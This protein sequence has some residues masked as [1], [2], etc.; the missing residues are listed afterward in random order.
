MRFATLL[1]LG[2]SVLAAQDLA[3]PV[4][5]RVLTAGSQPV[6]GARVVVTGDRGREVGVT[7]SQGDGRWSIPDLPPGDLHIRAEK[8]G[9]AEAFRQVRVPASG[10][11]TGIALHIDRY[12]VLGGRIFDHRGRPVV[13][14]EPVLFEAMPAG[15]EVRYAPARLQGTTV[16]ATDDRGVFRIWGILPGRYLVAVAPPSAPSV[17]GTVL[18]ESS[19]AFY[20][21]VISA[22]EATP[23]ELGWAVV[24]E[25]LDFRLPP[26]GKTRVDIRLSGKGGRV[27]ALGGGEH[28]RFPMA[29]VSAHNNGVV[30]L[31]GLPPGDYQLIA[32]GSTPQSERPV[33]TQAVQD[34]QIP[35][36]R[37][38]LFEMTPVKPAPLKVRVI[39]E[40][41]PEPP[42]S[43]DARPRFVQVFLQSPIPH[44]DGHL[45]RSDEMTAQF[46]ATEPE[47]ILEMATLPGRRRMHVQAG[48]GYVASVS[49]DGR[50]LQSP[51]L[52]APPEGFEGE[53]KIVIRFD[54]GKVE[55]RVD[56]PTAPVAAGLQPMPPTIYVQSEASKGQFELPRPA[57]LG[58]DGTFSL[59]LGP[60]VYRLAAMEPRPGQGML[61]S[62]ID[63]PEARS[64]SRRVEVKAGQ[65]TQVT[66]ELE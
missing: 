46:R 62:W 66:L 40:D 61:W 2:V 36:G 12:A 5:G 15:A 49:L 47:A 7:H 50:P 42:A 60:G 8:S 63:E 23:V 18:L 41:M 13:G 39:L 20:P 4:S 17:D 43:G 57:R 56:M 32:E 52:D 38:A 29:S 55:G 64:R 22:A 65:T 21:G 48:G 11:L 58:P 1:L 51:W 53:L 19:P 44:D 3:I 34:V 35:E 9:F 10:D 26:P 31:E 16:A 30:R 59:S 6:G 28:A 25:G 27:T 37:P 54:V 14:A 24:R 45:V 33:R